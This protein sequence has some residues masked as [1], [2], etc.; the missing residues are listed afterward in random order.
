MWVAREEPNLLPAPQDS[1]D[2]EFADGF[3]LDFP[4]TSE[5]GAA[6]LLVSVLPEPAKEG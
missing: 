4:F 2:C 3:S 5:D 1:L 6:D